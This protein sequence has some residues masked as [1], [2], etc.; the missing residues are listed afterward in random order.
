MT[1]GWHRLMS[2]PWGSHTPQ[3]IEAK[4]VALLQYDEDTKR[5]WARRNMSV[6]TFQSDI[7]LA[8]VAI[9]SWVPRLAPA[10]ADYSNDIRMRT[11]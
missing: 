5:F 2:A 3:A 7:K 10:F 9:E 8:P 6:P 4:R 11:R 1:E